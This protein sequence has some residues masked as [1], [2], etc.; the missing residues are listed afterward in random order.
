M[1]WHPEVLILSPRL[2]SC[3]NAWKCYSKKGTSTL[4]FTQSFSV[5]LCLYLGLS[6]QS[7]SF[8][9]FF[10]L[11]DLESTILFLEYFVLIYRFFFFF[12]ISVPKDI[13]S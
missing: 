1:G 7:C 11:R 9:F 8:T 3:Q 6:L 2:D 5:L 13:D 4:S 10:T 12:A